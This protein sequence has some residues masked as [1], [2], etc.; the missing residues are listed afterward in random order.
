[1]GKGTFGKVYQCRDRKHNDVVAVKVVRAIERYIDSARIEGDLLDD[2][3]EQQAAKKQSFC[4]KMFS[5]FRLDG[6][7]FDC[8][9]HLV[10]ILNA[11][12][13]QHSALLHGI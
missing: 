4:V 12:F 10:C 1:M 8:L 13:L 3:Y 7:L 2:I 11:F 6:S 5:R 9:D